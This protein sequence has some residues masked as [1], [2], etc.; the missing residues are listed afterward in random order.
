ML[1]NGWKTGH[2]NLL[3][4]L[5]T[6]G[7]HYSPSNERSGDFPYI[8]AKNIKWN[9]ID[10]SNL[11]YVPKTEHET[12]YRRCPVKPNDV[13]LIKDG[14]TTGV[15]AINQLSYPF[16]ML[17]SVALIRPS[18]S[19]LDNRYLWHW[20]RS[21]AAQA[22]LLGAMNGSAIRR[23][24]LTAIG[25][26]ELPVPPLAEQRRIV[27]KLG[28]LTA[29]L[30]SARAELDRVPRLVLKMKQ[31]AMTACFTEAEGDQTRL[32]LQL[33]FCRSS[34]SMGN[35]DSGHDEWRRVG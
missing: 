34:E 24:T 15:A 31:Q 32:A 8:T 12:I 19:M 11:T 23:L 3:C 17:S 1:P 13:L 2:L 5:L 9:G 16:S 27:A 20:I 4:D 28:A 10:L 6:D 25:Q 7:T 26:A 14:A 21:P 29:H 22:A 35:H 30:G 33:P 18:E